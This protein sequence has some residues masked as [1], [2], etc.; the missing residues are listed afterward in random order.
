MLRLARPCRS[1]RSISLARSAVRNVSS[2]AKNNSLLSQVPA[3]QQ[4][5]AFTLPSR[6]IR[7]LNQPRDFYNTLINMIQNAKRRIL[8]SSLYIGT[9]ETELINTLDEALS[10]NPTLTAHLLLDL[11]RSTRLESRS[12]IPSTAHLLAPLKEKYGHRLSVQMFR[13]PKLRGFMEHIVPPRF[14]EGW[15]TWHAKLYAADDDFMI[16]GANLNSSYFSDRQDRYVHISSQ[17]EIVKYLSNFLSTLSHSSYRLVSPD[18]PNIGL[19][20]NPPF[21]QSPQDQAYRLEWCNDQA[22]PRGYQPEANKAIN[23]LQ[24]STYSSQASESRASDHDTVIYPLIQSGVLGVRE[25]EMALSSLF[26]YLLSNAPQAE[27]DRTIVDLT[28]GYF[29]LYEPY[30]LRAMREG[31]DWRILAASPKANGFYGSR[32]VSGRIPEGYTL[33]EQRF[34]TR[35]LRAGRQ[36]RENGGGVALSE[37]YREAWTYHAKGI[38]ITPQARAPS[39]QGKP[40]P[41]RNPSITLFGSTNLNSRSA[42]LDT[43]LSFLLETT[44]PVLQARLGEEVRHLWKDSERMN[45]DAWAKQ[46]R[47]V[48]GVSLGTKAIMSVVGDML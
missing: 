5:P 25:E 43:E 4:Q 30:Q 28:S 9:E 18:G 26:D 31:L 44:S 33:L 35:V 36:W 7:I 24:N 10:R 14:N 48:G 22:H 47:K 2:N 8:I 13:S 45:E 29:A 21:S 3:L 16:S 23:E 46:G 39:Q 34:W 27:K 37:W 20:V 40:S 12:P 11:N 15:G 17:P 1:L 41:P 19:P 32:G 38:W 42:N 6:C